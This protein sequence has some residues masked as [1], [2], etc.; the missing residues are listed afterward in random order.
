MKMIKWFKKKNDWKKWLKKKE[1]EKYHSKFSLFNKEKI[2]KDFFS[3]IWEIFEQ[4]VKRYF[5]PGAN[6]SGMD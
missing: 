4:M 6:S 1:K 5:I 3:F 2:I